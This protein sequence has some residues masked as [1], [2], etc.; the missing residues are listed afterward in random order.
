MP[1]YALCSIVVAP[2]TVVM[3]VQFFP[4]PHGQER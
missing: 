1:Q 2:K 4:T 3:S